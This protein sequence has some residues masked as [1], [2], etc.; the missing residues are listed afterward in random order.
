MNW[1]ARTRSRLLRS[2]LCAD[3]LTT[4]LNSLTPKPNGYLVVLLFRFE[5]NPVFR[6]GE[7]FSEEAQAATCSC[8][9]LQKPLDLAH[10]LGDALLFLQRCRRELLGRKMLEVYFAARVLDVEITAVLENIDGGD[11]PGLVVLFSLVPPGDAVGKFF[12]LNRLGLRVVLSAFGERLL[13]VPDVFC[14]TGAIE[15]EKIRRNARVGSKDAVGEADDGVE[16][17]VFEQ[18]FLDAGADTIA[19]QR[20]VGDDDARS[21]S[22][23]ISDLNGESQR[24]GR[25]GTAKL[26]HDELE[27]EQ[28]GFGSLLVFWKVG[29]DAALFFA[30]EGGI[31]Q[32]D[33]HTIAV[34]D[35]F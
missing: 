14:G 35:F 25:A 20:A 21:A 27:K 24:R 8:A 22:P 13:V 17:E 11:F 28:G 16:I 3:H 12:E 31:G 19:E 1:F 10:N 33:V 29:E 26:A 18:F 15:E 7:H 23:G 4:Q 5:D 30:A 6:P 2:N 9:T 34:A 32:D